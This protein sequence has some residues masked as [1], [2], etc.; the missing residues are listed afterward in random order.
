MENMMKFIVAK[1]VLV[2]L[3]STT[4]AHTVFDVTAEGAKPEG[5]AS[6]ALMAAWG[7][8][9]ACTEPS[10]ILIPKGLFLLSPVT[11][12]GPCKCAVELEVQGTLKAS[13]NNKAGKEG[14]WVTFQRIDQFTLTGEGIFD[15]QGEKAWGACGTNF[16]DKLPINI[17]FDFLNNSLVQGITSLNS[18]QFHIN[19]LGCNNLTFQSVHVTAPAESLNTDGIHIG[20]SCGVNIIDTI[21]HTGD[22]CVSIGDGAKNVS[23]TNVE[24]G[25]GHGIAIGSLGKFE[26][27]EPVLG[28]TIKNCTLN[29]TDNG[30]RIKTWPAS[31]DNTA[32]SIHF[33]G[34]NMNN[35]SNPILIDQ[36]YCPWNR[37]NAKVP[38][39]VKLSDISFKN[40]KGTSSTPLLMK[41]VCSSGIPCEAVEV[42]DIDIKYTGVGPTQAQCT[43]VKPTISGVMSLPECTEAVAPTA[44]VAAGPAA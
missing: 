6:Q 10:K 18:K 11:L 4:R 42:A 25:P 33:E 7:K 14:G 12:Q 29:N 34:I 13:S 23:V 37:C 3:V 15:G 36:V 43:N 2:L 30:V 21:I 27:E 9:C 26:N 28:I 20:R 22:D 39:R 19:V 16:C 1:F 44:A 32:S 17:R 40:I 24:C 31:T 5:D 35:V 41:L 8:A 38:S